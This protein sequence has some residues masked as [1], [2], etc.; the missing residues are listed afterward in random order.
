MGGRSTGSFKIDQG[1]LKFKGEVV[2]V[3]SLEA[4]GFIKIEAST[5]EDVSSCKAIVIKAK[6]NEKYDGYH[7]SFG[8][9]KNWICSFFSSGFKRH[10]DVP[11]D[12]QF[13]EVKLAFNTFSNCNSDGTGAQIKTCADH[14][15]VCPNTND[16][17]D[18]TPLGIWGEGK[19]GKVDLEVQSIFATDCNAATRGAMSVMAIMTAMLVI[20]GW[21]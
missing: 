11:A 2:N 10:F 9:R 3:P 14:P 17:R 7:L 12:G 21:L 13:H 8:S 5:F 20:G 1:L 6:T 16:L 19:A 4:P 15:D 18:V